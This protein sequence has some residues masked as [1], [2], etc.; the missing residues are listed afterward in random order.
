MHLTQRKCN[1]VPCKDHIT[2][3][4]ISFCLL[5]LNVTVN[6]LTLI[7]EIYFKPIRFYLGIDSLS[8]VVNMGNAT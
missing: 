6:V 4:E 5:I 3:V 8:T 2:Y 1:Y 7:N